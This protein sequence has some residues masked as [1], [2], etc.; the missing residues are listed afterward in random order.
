[1]EVEWRDLTDLNETLRYSSRPNLIVR[2]LKFLERGGIIENQHLLQQLLRL[3][4][5]FRPHS[6]RSNP[7]PT[8]RFSLFGLHLPRCSGTQNVLTNEPRVLNRATSEHWC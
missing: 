7:F 1:M 2:L 3:C 6:P 4:G 5:H 8:E